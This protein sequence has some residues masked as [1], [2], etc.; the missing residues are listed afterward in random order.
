MPQPRKYPTTGTAVGAAIEFLEN[1]SFTVRNLLNDKALGDECQRQADS[2]YDYLAR[3][4]H[5]RGSGRTEAERK[6]RNQSIL[7]RG[8]QKRIAELEEKLLLIRV[9]TDLHERGLLTSGAPDAGGQT[10]RMKRRIDHLEAKLLII[11]ELSDT[12]VGK[13]N[14][15]AVP[16]KERQIHDARMRVDLH[17]GLR[18]RKPVVN[19]EK[20]QLLQEH[21]ADIEKSPGPL[22]GDVIPYCGEGAC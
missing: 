6:A 16:E 13:L 10:R 20:V 5:R 15:A 8:Y 21:L 19:P 11:R 3:N 7:L 4:L 12:N 14:K 22:Q 1:L 2:L 17:N 18:G 9:S